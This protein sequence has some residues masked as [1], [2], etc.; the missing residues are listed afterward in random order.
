MSTEE[1]E[2]RIK[3]LFDEIE[4]VDEKDKSAIIAYM[5]GTRETRERICLER[6]KEVIN[7]K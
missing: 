3:N 6:K 1:K 2:Q 4:K 7:K 5:Q